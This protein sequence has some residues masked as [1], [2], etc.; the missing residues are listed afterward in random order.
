MKT[1]HNCLEINIYRIII[2]IW[3][4]S[5]IW[6]DTVQYVSTTI[7]RRQNLKKHIYLSKECSVQRL[8][9]LLEKNFLL[10]L[11][12][13]TNDLRLGAKQTLIKITDCV[14]C[15]ALSWRHISHSVEFPF[16]LFYFLLKVF[17]VF[18]IIPGAESVSVL[19]SPETARS[20]SSVL[21][22][23]YHSVQIMSFLDVSSLI[24]SHPSSMVN[25]R[26]GPSRILWG[27]FWLS[28]AL[29]PPTNVSRSSK[30]S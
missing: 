9:H 24:R 2:M 7:L 28:A 29:P 21:L 20:L 30:K 8:C 18:S 16:S 22:I 11:C 26:E 4:I 23:S 10:Q 6:N 1:P 15:S 25:G 5:L 3:I 17:P 19:A 12:T 27:V 14:W 13:F